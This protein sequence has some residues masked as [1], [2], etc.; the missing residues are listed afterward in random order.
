MKTLR[1]CRKSCNIKFSKEKIYEFLFQKLRIFNNKKRMSK[2]ELANKLKVNQST[3]FR[4]EN[5]DMGVTVNNAYDVADFFNVSMSDLNGKDMSLENQ[6]FDE[7]EI[8]FD[9]NKEILTDE[10][11][12]TIKF[13]IEKRKREIDKQLD[14]E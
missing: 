2:N 10:D 12:E 1:F 6:P 9:K 13:L 4:W 14:G 3:I 11:K 8:L 7:L 5:G